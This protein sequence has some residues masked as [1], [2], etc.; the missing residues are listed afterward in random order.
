MK[1]SFIFCLLVFIVCS[2]IGAQYFLSSEK[3]KKYML[4]ARDPKLGTY[5]VYHNGDTIK[6]KHIEV[7][8]N[9][10]SG[11]KKWTLDGKTVDDLEEIAVF[12]DEGAYVYCHLYT[13]TDLKYSLTFG[14]EFGRLVK[15]KISL[16]F[17]K[18]AQATR[19]DRVD[20]STYFFL[21][22]DPTRLVNFSP[23]SE[24]QLADM[25][26]DCPPAVAKMNELFKTVK[27]KVTN[28]YEKIIAVL[29]V[30]NEKK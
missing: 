7:K 26:A 4:E 9:A 12:Q 17:T 6:G 24:K 20:K 18:L 28:D 16:F 5:I 27:N 30:Y 13:S 8:N 23:V 19:E 14:Q 10:F 1:K 21:S 22:T 25:V 2:Q 15:G 29:K 11:K 3:L